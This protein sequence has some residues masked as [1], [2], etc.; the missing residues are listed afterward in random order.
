VNSGG[1]VYLFSWS[2][3]VLDYMSYSDDMHLSLVDDSKGI[4][5]ER[6]SFN[7]EG[8]ERSNWHSAASVFR[9]ATPGK[10]NSQYYSADHGKELLTLLPAVFSPD[11]DGFE[12]MLEIRLNPGRAGFVL[13]MD[14]LDI[15]GG[16]IRRLSNNDILGAENSYFWDGQNDYGS[17]VPEG[18]YLLHAVMF[19]PDRH[20]K[21]RIKKAFALIYR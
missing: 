17:M 19:H 1:A 16:L 10:S 12:D 18:M 8:S 20:E 14:V 21:K 15:S 13:Q 9:Y 7:T 3:T 2:G 6:I 5:L 4:S 11:N